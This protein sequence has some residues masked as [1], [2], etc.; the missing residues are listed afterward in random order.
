MENLETWAVCE[1]HYQRSKAD[2]HFFHNL[3]MTIL[4][5]QNHH[6]V[7]FYSYALGEREG[8]CNKSSFCTLVEMMKNGRPLSPCLQRKLWTFFFQKL[9]LQQNFEALGPNT[10]KST[11]VEK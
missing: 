3:E 4:I 9:K 5:Q 10:R 2:V 8:V 7:A 11:L 1:Q 6:F